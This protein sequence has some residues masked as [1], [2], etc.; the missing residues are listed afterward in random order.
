M[1]GA[2]CIATRRT[3]ATRR[4]HDTF[5][6]VLVTKA[7]CVAQ[8]TS[9]GKVKKVARW[10]T[11]GPMMTPNTQQKQVTHTSHITCQFTAMYITCQF[12]AMYH[13][14]LEISCDLQWLIR[15]WDGQKLSSNLTLSGGVW[16]KFS[17]FLNCLGSMDINF[18][19]S[20][21]WATMC[22][23]CPVYHLFWKQIYNFSL[24]SDLRFLICLED[25]QT[26]HL[27]SHLFGVHGS[28]FSR[29]S[30]PVCGNSHTH[31]YA[32]TRSIQEPPFLQGFM[33]QSSTFVSQFAPV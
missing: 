19:F 16:A 11:A 28:N 9:A 13:I 24:V 22:P 10:K 3:I 23:I 27:V 4:R 33:A 12:T 18:T 7:A 21:V 2:I 31:L 15:A 8:T 1:I 26:V 17:H 5:I 29:Q 14:G 32:F 25:M 30:R 6:Y 20:P